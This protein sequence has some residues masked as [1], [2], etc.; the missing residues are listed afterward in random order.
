MIS[1]DKDIAMNG[2]TYLDW[3]IRSETSG[4]EAHF[5]CDGD[6]TMSQKCAVID[7]LTSE[8]IGPVTFRSHTIDYC[9]FK[10]VDG[11]ESQVKTCHLQ[12]SR[13][14]LLGRL[15][16]LFD[17]TQLM[18]F[19]LRLVSCCNLQYDQV[20]LH[21]VDYILRSWTYSLHIG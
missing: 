14:I 11:Y 18:R 10:P 15:P 3:G 19:K 12:G 13:Q 8:N 6:P 21:L 7:T 1:S 17:K 2:Y 9:L 5:L 20:L 16:S 4:E